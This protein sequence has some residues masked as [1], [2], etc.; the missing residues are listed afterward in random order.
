[1]KKLF[2]AIIVVAVITIGVLL[3]TKSSTKNGCAGEDVPCPDTW[4][5]TADP[6]SK[7]C[8]PATLT[9]VNGGYGGPNNCSVDCPTGYFPCWDDGTQQG[10]CRLGTTKDTACVTKCT[11]TS[12]KPNGTCDPTL[13]TCKCNPGFTGA[14]CEKA[15]T[16]TC[17]TQPVG[18]CNN[19]LCRKDTGTCVCNPGWYG[20]LCDNPGKC[21]LS[22]CRA[23]DKNAYCSDPNGLNPGD[24]VCSPGHGPSNGQ[25]ACSTC[26]SG[27]GPAVGT[28]PF[29]PYLGTRIAACSQQL[30]YHDATTGAP[31]VFSLQGGSQGDDRSNWC[32][33]LSD[34][35]T[36]AYFTERCQAAFGP[37]SSSNDLN[38]ESDD[39]CRGLGVGRLKCI[40]PAYYTSVGVDPN[41]APYA[42]CNMGGSDG[43]SRATTL[44]PP[45]FLPAQ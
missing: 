15:I 3:A 24:C 11:A 7:K 26:L 16:T 36:Q 2:I 31:T 28:N 41:A 40:V 23:V 5:G 27:Y 29:I 14:N 39:S 38:C 4:T 12:C 19:G 45:G 37:S 43:G 17:I 33:S 10:Q 30:D 42:L 8:D 18:Y 6:A 22:I 35:H 13:F 21:D 32:F 20:D 34:E 9:W 44:L 25:T 1:M